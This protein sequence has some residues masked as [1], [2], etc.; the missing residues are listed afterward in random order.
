M[1][2]RKFRNRFICLCW[3]CQ[4]ELAQHCFEMNK[5][6]LKEKLQELERKCKTEEHVGCKVV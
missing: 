6:Q 3:K 5:T 2:G 4:N 1:T